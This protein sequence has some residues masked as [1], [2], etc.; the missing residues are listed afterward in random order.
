[1]YAIIFCLKELFYNS[2]I[3]VY[4]RLYKIFLVIKQPVDIVVG[5]YIYHCDYIIIII[6]II[7]YGLDFVHPQQSLYILRKNKW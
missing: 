3:K 6:M 2:K 4:V 5:I 7:L 1:M